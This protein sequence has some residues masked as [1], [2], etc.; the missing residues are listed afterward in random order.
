MYA[1]LTSRNARKLSLAP[2]NAPLAWKQIEKRE[3]GSGW[4][5]ASEEE[6]LLLSV[7]EDVGE[8]RE[9]ELHLRD[10]AG[11]P[12]EGE[13][14]RRGARGRKKAVEEREGKCYSQTADCC[15]GEYRL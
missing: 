7:K 12:E 4:Y 10:R 1:S 2:E 14:E 13:R 3:A 8:G 15:R 9:E 5:L 6:H 11:E